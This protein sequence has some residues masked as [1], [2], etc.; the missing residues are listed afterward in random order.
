MK[1]VCGFALA[2]MLCSSCFAGSDFDADGDDDVLMQNTSTGIWRMVTFQDGSIAQNNPIGIY[3]SAD[4]E[5]QANLDVD[6]DLDDDILM[7]NKLNGGWR[8]FYIQAGAIL[9]N[10]PFSGL[11]TSQNYEFMAAFDADKD[12]DDDV[13]LRNMLT[14]GWRLFAVQSG[15]VQGNSSL[16]LWSNLDQSFYAAGDFDG[17]GDGDIILRSPDYHRRVFEIESSAVVSYLRLGRRWNNDFMGFKSVGDFSADGHDDMLMRNDTWGGGWD[18]LGIFDRQYNTPN[19]TLVGAP[20][21]YYY[22][23]WGSGDFDNDGD[24]DVIIRSTDGGWRLLAIQNYAVV[25]DTT[26]SLYADPA[27]EKK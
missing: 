16:N 6:G 8:V 13:L 10:A 2:T 9:S 1:I 18:V 26:L 20:T 11:Y 21:G 7:R 25:S 15:S 23:F 14:G 4:W 19:Q 24:D 5:H 12:G 27:W 22:G 3:T 17:D